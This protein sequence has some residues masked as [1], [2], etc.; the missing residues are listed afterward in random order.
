MHKNTRS[1]CF[2]FFDCC[3]YAQYETNENGCKS[4][5]ITKSNQNDIKIENQK[6]KAFPQG[7]SF[8]C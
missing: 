4:L 2:I 6:K 1:N 8:V 5:K 7:N 3:Q